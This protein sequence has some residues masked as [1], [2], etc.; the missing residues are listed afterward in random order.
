M[1]RVTDDTRTAWKADASHKEIEI[2]I[3]AAEITLTNSDVLAESL[4][5]R[6]AIET[7]QNLTFTGC[8]ASYLKFECFNLVDETLEGK[9]IEADIVA[10]DENGDETETIPL[11]RGSIA[12]VTNLTHEEFTTQIEAYDDLYKINNAD[13]TA[14]RNSLTFPISLKNLRDSFFTYLGVTQKADYLPNDGIS[15]T[16]PQLEDAVI[17]GD[18][19]V[20][21]IC[22]INGRYGRIGRNGLFEY[23]HLVE[24]TEAVYP[25][26]DLYPAD[27]LYPSDENATESVAKAHYYSINFENYRVAVIDR[28]QIV[29]KD[30]TISATIGSGTNTFTLKDN[31]LTW[32]LNSATL[33]QVA[34]NLYNDIQGLWYTPSQIEAIGLPY[35]ETGDF[36]LM[37]AQRSIIRAYVLQRTFKG[38]QAATDNYVANGDRKQPNYVP[39]VQSQINAN[40]MAITQEAERASGAETAE[41]NRA[42]SAENGLNN[43]IGSVNNRV[44]G[45]YAELVDTQ[46]LVATKASIQDLQVT[47]NL[48]ATK[49]DISTLNAV[50]AK[51]DNLSAKAITTDNLRASIGGFSSIYMN[52]LYVNDVYITGNGGNLPDKVRQWA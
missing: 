26:E 6:E 51:I 42:Q 2:R 44:S 30:G 9:R 10:L 19:I 29:A 38:I 28:L 7:G 35:V 24:A 32:G 12:K 46:R 1:Y 45:V 23:V 52:T 13:V 39:S 36:V 21:A 17:T 16:S 15:I 43:A 41:R 49:A 20:K 5:L 4:E 11:F 31:P 47:N 22:Q 40:S 25:A 27:D 14:W 3:P 34:Q 48:I 18:K 50:N 37:V 8:I 33:G